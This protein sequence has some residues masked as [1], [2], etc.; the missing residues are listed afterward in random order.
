M[1]SPAELLA[2]VAEQ[3]RLAATKARWR[4]VVATSSRG[5][6]EQMVHTFETAGEPVFFTQTVSLSAARLQ[7]FGLR[8]ALLPDGPPVRSTCFTPVDGILLQDR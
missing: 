8:D 6:A 7:M 2:G 3:E 1:V 5:L 4:H